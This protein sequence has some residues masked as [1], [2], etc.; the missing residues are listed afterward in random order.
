M[1]SLRQARLVDK[2]YL[3]S[4][5]FNRLGRECCG[6]AHVNFSWGCFISWAFEVNN[7]LKKCLTENLKRV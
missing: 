4:L 3:A 1:V 2:G 5:V 7:F 6:C